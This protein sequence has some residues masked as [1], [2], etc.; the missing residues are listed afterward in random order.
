ML[1]TDSALVAQ[2]HNHSESTDQGVYLTGLK[3]VI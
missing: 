1:S 2:G 3:V